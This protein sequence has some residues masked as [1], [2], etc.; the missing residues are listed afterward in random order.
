MR[1]GKGWFEVT[2]AGE[3]N[4]RDVMA[5]VEKGRGEIDKK[6]TVEK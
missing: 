2:E 6:R 4:E 5:W 3:R 1:V